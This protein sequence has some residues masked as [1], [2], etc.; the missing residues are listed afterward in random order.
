MPETISFVQDQGIISMILA[1]SPFVRVVLLLLIVL[2]ICSWAITIAKF[3]QFRKAKKDS[4]E[5]GTIFW[6]TRNFARIEDSSRRLINSPLAQVFTSGF[7]ELNNLVHESEQVGQRKPDPT[8]DL[9]TV[10]RALK[11][12]EFDEALKL[13]QGTTFLATVASAAPFIGLFGTVW[14]IMNAFHGLSQAKSST[15]Q[16][17]APG[18]SEALVTT[19][20]GLLAAIPAAVAY[21]YFAVAVRHFRESMDKFSSEFIDVARRYF[22]K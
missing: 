13:E 5:F 20:I 19:A 21:N 18:I 11:R 1:S 15:I 6:E 3:L 22:L 2:S 17:V 12:S 16:A 10:E 4:D 14:G 8:S 7:R 9:H